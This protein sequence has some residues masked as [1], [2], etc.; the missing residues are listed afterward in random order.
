MPVA[1]RIELR[2]SVYSHGCVLLQPTQD[3]PDR[4]HHIFGNNLSSLVG[5]QGDGSNMGE[6]EKTARKV[7]EVVTKKVCDH[8]LSRKLE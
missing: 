6:A 8:R 1:I 4:P 7:E 2:V 5:N 3:K